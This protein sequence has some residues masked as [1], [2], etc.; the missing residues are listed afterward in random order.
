MGA[1][2]LDS[3][4]SKLGVKEKLSLIRTLWESIPVD[5][6]EARPLSQGELDE[7]DRRVGAYRRDP[8]SGVA[9]EDLDDAIR[10]RR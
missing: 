1:T 10:R 8:T 9:L 3:E 5:E 2:H 4:I 6:L 7:L